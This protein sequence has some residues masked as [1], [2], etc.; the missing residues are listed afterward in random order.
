ML[1]NFVALRQELCKISAVENLCSRKSG[2]KFT[3]TGDDQLRTNFIALGQTVYEKSIAIFLHHSIFWRL[4]GPSVPK[5][6]NLGGG[7]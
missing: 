4:R 7:I 5:F 2:P 6:T 1:P 3:K